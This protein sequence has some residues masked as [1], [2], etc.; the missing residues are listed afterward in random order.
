[1]KKAL[2]LTLGIAACGGGGKG[3]GP[4]E[5]DTKE[6]EATAE[7]APGSTRF[8]GLDWGDSAAD[9]KADYPDAVVDGDTIELTARVGG[10][11][12]AASLMLTGDQLIAIDVAFADQFP[13]MGDCQPVFD[14]VRAELDKSLG[15]SSEDNL[16]AYW[17]DE[18]AF[19]ELA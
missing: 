5:P 10:K 1:M 6:P 8:P 16:A 11:D 12:A 3:G 4:T 19:V 9:V 14:Q 2:F 17:T 18:S 7:L 13:S 15:E